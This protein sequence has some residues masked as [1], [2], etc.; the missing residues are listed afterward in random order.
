MATAVNDRSAAVSEMA[1]DWAMLEAIMQGTTAMRR[2]GEAFLPKFPAEDVESFKA[3]LM[4]AT[5]FPALRRTVSVMAGK[6][7]SKALTLSDDTPIEIRGEQ[8]KPAMGD[9][10]AVPA[11]EGW[12]DDIDRQGVNLH[13]FAAEM[14]AEALA[15]GFCGILVEAPKP[16]V[17]AGRVPTRAE[18]AA[19]GVRPYFVRVMHGQILGWRAE[20]RNGVLTLTQLRLA[21]TV[22]IPDGEF[23]EKTVNR[24]RVLEPGAWRVFEEDE[25]AGPDGKR[26]WIE[27]DSGATTLSVIPFVP[28]YGRRMG[29]MRGVSPLLDLAHLNV[30][31]WQ[32]QSDQDTILHVARV[33]I[34]AAIGADQESELVVGSKAMVRMPLGSD[35]K[36]VEHTGAAIGKGQES[37][38][39]LED[40]MI[41]AGAELLVK[42]PGDRS[43]TEAAND[44]EANKSDLQRIA[45]GFE[46]ALDQALK[47]MAAY[48]G[49]KGGGSVSL[50]KDYGATN[51]SDASG[52]L[53]LAMRK[54]GLISTSTAIAELKRRGEL[55]A[56]VDPEAEELAV[57]EEQQGLEPEAPMDP[58]SGD[59]LVPKDPAQAA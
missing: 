26:A 37:L 13:T 56:E 34:L 16:I 18:E 35:L 51:L 21:E 38:D 25:K 8:G 23:G 24:V 17:P 5:L 53:V 47:L 39:K 48:A 28:V 54:D 55:A 52:H 49:L 45:E 10:P 59:P 36:F 42:K 43:A 33:P 20:E 22:T 15:Y 4:T 19:A 31:H 9:K 29:F 44:A 41:Q 30:K 12:A 58:A 3:R 2:A 50:F 6:P 7:F 27:I 14:M 32:S 57:A 40:Q 46:D 11:Q 1:Q